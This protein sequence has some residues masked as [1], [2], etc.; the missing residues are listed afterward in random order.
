[1]FTVFKTFQ[2]DNEVQPHWLYRAIN[3]KPFQSYESRFWDTF[4]HLYL[5]SVFK[6]QYLYSQKLPP[7]QKNN[8]RYITI[9]T[10]VDHSNQR[11]EIIFNRIS[12]IQLYRLC[13]HSIVVFLLNDILP[14]M[15]VSNCRKKHDDGVLVINRPTSNYSIA[16]SMVIIDKVKERIFIRTIFY[17]NRICKNIKVHRRLKL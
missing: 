15:V 13:T 1:M 5:P 16:T 6:R 11:E 10:T 9:T 8:N 14:P 12:S 7:S 3:Y 4:K 2:N 17:R